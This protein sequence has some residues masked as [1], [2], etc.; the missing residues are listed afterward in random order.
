MAEL[1]NPLTVQYR[2]WGHDR[3]WKAR[4]FAPQRRHDRW[5]LIDIFLNSF[6]LFSE[7]VMGHGMVH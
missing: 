1:V 6:Q 2:L 7:S 3:W 4:V 5:L